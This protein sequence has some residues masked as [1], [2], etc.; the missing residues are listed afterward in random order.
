[1]QHGPFSTFEALGLN[2]RRGPYRPAG[3]ELKWSHTNVRPGKCG[4]PTGMLH[5]PPST[6]RVQQ[7]QYGTLGPGLM[8]LTTQTQ[9]CMD[10]AS[11][12]MSSPVR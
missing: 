12:L 5:S 7:F 9:L 1:M 3:V 11:R 6:F 4:T 2:V 8:E 10:L